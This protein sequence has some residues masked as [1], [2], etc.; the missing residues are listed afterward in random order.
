MK[1][2]FSFQVETA[3]CFIS[4]EFSFLVHKLFVPVVCI[5]P[6]PPLLIPA[7]TLFGLVALWVEYVGV[8]QVFAVGLFPHPLKG[9]EDF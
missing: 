1:D 5:I 6:F 8:T 3:P 2:I 7:T 9:E 4:F